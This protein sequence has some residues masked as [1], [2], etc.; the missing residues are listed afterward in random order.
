MNPAQSTP[1]QNE[2]ADNQPSV[3]DAVRTLLTSARK[4]L[5]TTHRNPDGD[6]MGSAL[7]LSWLLRSHG[8]QTVVVV[9]TPVPANL[10]WMPGA[11]DVVVYEEGKAVVT[12]DIDLICV[13]DLNAVSRLAALGE[14]L[15]SS[16]RPI[17][18]IDH[19]THPEDFA[20][21]QWIDT[22]AAA[23]AAMIVT[24]SRGLW[25]MT[26]EAATCLYAGILTDT[27]GF[28]FPRTTSALLRD[29]ADLVDAGADPV[30]IYDEIYN[31]S[32][33][34]RT[35]LLGK[36]LSTME[37]HAG[38]TICTMIVTQA[39]LQH[40]GCSV[41][42]TD[43]FVSNTLA[44]EGVRVGILFVEIPG[45]SKTSFRSKGTMY[46][47]DLAAEYGGGGHN[48]AAGARIPTTSFAETVQ[49]VIKRAVEYVG[50]A[51]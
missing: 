14:E 20:R 19:H 46:V 39:D 47:R 1:A 26:A 2:P 50:D 31:Q 32:S 38:G 36:A 28:R 33:F 9:P 45:Y 29:V 37:L 30:R 35:R 34:G 3:I 40:Y 5:L 25:Q 15:I 13:L 12:H 24:L 7:G 4:V 44:L 11:D 8:L 17:V 27:G 42:D 23:T 43:G 16:G 49:S 18:N 51:G 10:L 48:Y 21:L 41:D 6:A 22:S